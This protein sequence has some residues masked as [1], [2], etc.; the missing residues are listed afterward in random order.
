[1][2]MRSWIRNL[3]TRPVTRTIR[4]AA[5]PARPA[6]EVLEDRWCRPRSS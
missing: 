1:M 4:K 3:F 6:L 5:T 2:T